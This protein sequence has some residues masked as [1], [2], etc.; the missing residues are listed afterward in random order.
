MQSQTFFV[1]E[2]TL[3]ECGQGEHSQ[4]ASSS[5]FVFEIQNKQQKFPLKI[6]ANQKYIFLKTVSIENQW[7]HQFPQMEELSG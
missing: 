7:F 1:H 4:G 3:L 5:I 2:V 6:N